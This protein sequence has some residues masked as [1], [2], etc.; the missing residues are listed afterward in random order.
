MTKP[1]FES[2]L[3]AVRRETAA[4]WYTKKTYES[5]KSLGISGPR[6]SA[7]QSYMT[8]QKSSNSAGVCMQHHSQH[9]SP[10]GPQL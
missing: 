1:S 5:S 6:L 8:R 10:V 3:P 4:A 9:F 7:Y 2:V